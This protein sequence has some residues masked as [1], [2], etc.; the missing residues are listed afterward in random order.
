MRRLKN[1]KY[2][3][4]EHK[5]L[6]LESDRLVAE[7][8]ARWGKPKPLTVS[9]KDLVW[10]VKYRGKGQ[11]PLSLEHVGTAVCARKKDKVYSGSLIKGIVVMHKS[12]LQPVIN[13]EQA[14][15]SAR[16]RRG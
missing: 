13:Q 4:A 11:E 10:D 1:V 3:S 15:D 2:R 12:C 14:I 7:Q 6:S 8:E 16:M 9:K 5:R